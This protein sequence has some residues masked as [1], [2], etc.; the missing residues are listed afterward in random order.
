VAG[1]AGWFLFLMRLTEFDDIAQALVG[2]SIGR[3]KIAPV[4]SPHKTWAG[5]V[6]GVLLTSLLAGLLGRWLTPWQPTVAML[7]GLLI[8][9]AGFLGDLNI[10]G[11]KRDRGVK[12]SSNL[13]PGQGGVLDRIDSLTFAAPAFYGFIGI[14][15][16]SGFG[17]IS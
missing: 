16:A 1:G 5:F 2:R 12:D 13:L 17:G 4:V 6:G 14:A 15:N 7:A 8:S 3:R 9:L 10:S 11:I